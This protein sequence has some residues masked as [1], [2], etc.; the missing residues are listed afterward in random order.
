[1]LILC[2]CPEC[3]SIWFYETYKQRICDSCGYI[4][5]L[6]IPENHYEPIK[7][8]YS[9]NDDRAEQLDYEYYDDY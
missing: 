7:K 1:M 4:E 5:K 6:K 8:N 3:D 9:F 2:K